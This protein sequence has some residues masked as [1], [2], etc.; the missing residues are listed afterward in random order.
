MPKVTV[1][2][3]QDES[4]NVDATVTFDP[5]LLPDMELPPTHRAAMNVFKGTALE[6]AVRAAA[7]VAQGVDAA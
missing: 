5:P 4:G 3:T 2:L 6:P 7:L 1:E